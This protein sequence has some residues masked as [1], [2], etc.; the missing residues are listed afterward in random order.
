MLKK[1]RRVVERKICRGDCLAP[2]VCSGVGLAVAVNDFEQGSHGA[3]VV[4]EEC[5]F[6]AFLNLE[7]DVL[8]EYFAFDRRGET[9]D[10]QNFVSYFTVGGEDDAGIAS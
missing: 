6:V 10:F 9:L 4:A 5:H 3:G 2:V 7:I 1:D 8:K